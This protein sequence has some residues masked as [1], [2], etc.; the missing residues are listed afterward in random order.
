MKFSFDAL[1]TYFRVP[2]E[3]PGLG[4]L[5]PAKIGE[6][7]ELCGLALEL[8]QRE[9]VAALNALRKEDP[10]Y[11]ETVSSIL[12]KWLRDRLWPRDSYVRLYPEY[13]AKWLWFC[14][15]LNTPGLTEDDAM[16]IA[17]HMNPEEL[18]EILFAANTI[19][20][21]RPDEPKKAEGPQSAAPNPSSTSG[22]GSPNSSQNNTASAPK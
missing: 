21:P 10:A 22:S 9:K 18:Y 6:I 16:E 8:L 15:R 3:I 7:K 19:R 4:R 5:V 11:A 14:A 2:Q 17:A 12:T 20:L 13:L 1:A